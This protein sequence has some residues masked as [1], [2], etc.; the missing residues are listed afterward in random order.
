MKRSWIFLTVAL[1]L[2]LASYSQEQEAKYRR[3][4]LYSVLI[5]HPEKEFGKDIDTVFRTVPIPDKFDDHNLKIRDTE[6]K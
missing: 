5:R 1:L 6:V 3:S 4:S 2:S